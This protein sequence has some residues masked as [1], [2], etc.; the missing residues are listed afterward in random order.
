MNRND[1]R[2]ADRGD[3]KYHERVDRCLE[4][5]EDCSLLSKQCEL[6]LHDMK[7]CWRGRLHCPL[8]KW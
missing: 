5:Q 4:V 2:D 7:P 1:D 6:C 3:Q 8:G